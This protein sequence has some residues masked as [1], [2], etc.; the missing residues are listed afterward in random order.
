MPDDGKE[1]RKSG[2]FQNSWHK[3]TDRRPDVQTHPV[4]T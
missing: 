4:H 1:K 2:P 3:A